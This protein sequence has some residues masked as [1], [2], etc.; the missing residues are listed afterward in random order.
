MTARPRPRTETPASLGYRMPAEWEPH[1]ATWIAWPHNRDD[2]PGKFAP[3]P[4]VYAEI[5][6]HLSRV[7]R[8]NILVQ[9]RKMR[10]GVAERLDATGST[11]SGSRS[12]RRPPTASGSATRARRSWS[13]RPAAEAEPDG[14]GLVDWRFN[15]WAKYDN[16]RHDDRLPRRLARRLGLRRWVPEVAVEGRA[17]DAGRDGGGRDRRQRPRHAADDRGVPA[18]RVQARN[19]GLDRAAL[20]RVFADY[21]GV[22]PRRLARPGDRRRR[23]PRTRRRPGAVR[24]SPDGRHGRR[25]APGRPQPRAP[26]GEPAAARGGARPGRPAAPRRRRCRCPSRSSSRASGCRPAT[27][28]STSPIGLVLVPTFNDPADRVALDTLAALFPD[29]EVVGIHAV[30]LVLG[31]GT[32]H[33]LSQQ[34]PAVPPPVIG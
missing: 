5:V 9:G 29:R 34:Q 24:R 17:G 30:D 8:V 18:Q 28:T 7:E 32:L 10:R 22:A 25:A 4:W 3:I 1:E 14:I 15:G 6:R 2:W 12:S 26:A 11:S 20:E 13:S 16:H 31:L 27:P 33:C 19:P 23:H 21:L